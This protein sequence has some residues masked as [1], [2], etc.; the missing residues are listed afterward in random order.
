MENSNSLY[1]IQREIIEFRDKRNWKKFHNLK[2]LLL[3]LNIECSE[4]QELFLW[5]N[6][7]EIKSVDKNQIQEEL[8]DIFIF[9]SYLCDYF[10][11]DILE[12]TENKIKL[13]EKKY[14]VGKSYNSNKKY[15]KL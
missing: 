4:L 8:A 15:N 10:D 14:P 12:A 6:K 3:G 11:I 2:D 13:N 9:L 5:K 7:K 1:E